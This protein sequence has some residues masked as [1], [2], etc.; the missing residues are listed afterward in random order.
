[1]AIQD[2]DFRRQSDRSVDNLRS[3]YAVLFGLS[4]GLT[5]TGT[6]AAGFAPPPS[7]WP[8]RRS[9]SRP[10]PGFSTSSPSPGTASR[11]EACQD[12]DGRPDFR[13]CSARFILWS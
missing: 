6:A 12:P 10:M 9:P 3:L 1:M 2:E 4:F 8:L 5:L 13:S 11:P 7:S